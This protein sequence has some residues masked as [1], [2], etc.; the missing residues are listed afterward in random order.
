MGLVRLKIREMA[1]EKGWTLKEVSERSG[2]IYNTVKS[3]AR[4]SEIATIDFISLQKL[5]RTFDVMIED[6]VEIVEE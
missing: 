2:V 5:A 6:L 1:A 3:Y 4:R